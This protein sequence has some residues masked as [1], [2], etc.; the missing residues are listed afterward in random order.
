MS[1]V[2]KPLMPAHRPPDDGA[3]IEAWLARAL[4]AQW[5]E[6]LQEA[7]PAEL[8]ALADQFSDDE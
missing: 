6:V 5:N 3:P 7:V 1:Y 4:A 2:S 8:A